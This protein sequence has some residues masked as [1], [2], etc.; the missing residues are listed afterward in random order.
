M[1]LNLAV[2]TL[3]LMNPLKGLTEEVIPEVVIVTAEVVEAEEITT[4]R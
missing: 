2:E 3:R 1:E 4:G